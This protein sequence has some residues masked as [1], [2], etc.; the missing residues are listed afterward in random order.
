MPAGTKYFRNELTDLDH[1]LR[2]G[3]FLPLH[4]VELNAVAFSERFAAATLNG[5][6]MNEAILA[7]IIEC[8]E[9]KT[10]VV[11]E[12]LYFTGAT[13][14]LTPPFAGGDATSGGTVAC[15]HRNVNVELARAPA[16]VDPL[17]S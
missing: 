9:A 12:P 6:V 16:L 3:T 1:V 17:F 11:V 5:F 2:R 14:T 15:C 10:F 13:H 8:D 4:D 7:P